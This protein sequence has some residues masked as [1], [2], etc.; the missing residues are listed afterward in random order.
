METSSS[1]ELLIAL[2]LLSGF[3]SAAETSLTTL[4]L[5]RVHDLVN[6]KRWSSHIIQRLKAHPEKL[7]IT[8]LIGNNIVNIWASVLAGQVATEYFGSHVVGYVVAVMTLVMLVFAEVLPKTL[9]QRFNTTF[10]QITSPLL[11]LLS[12]LFYPLIILLELLSRAFISLLGKEKFKTV[13]EDEVIAMLNIGHQEGEFN[14]QENEFIKNIFEFSD[15]TA[16]EIMTNRNEIEA[17]SY[18]ITLEEATR[19]IAKSSHTRIPIY[20]KEID[21]IIGYM[22]LKDII[23]LSKRKGNLQKKL[24]EFRLNKILFFPLSKPINV[25]FKN[26]QKE[27]IHIA[28]ILD[29]FGSTIGLVTM[30]DV[31]EEIVGDIEDEHDQEEKG[32]KRLNRSSYQVRGDTTMEELFTHH[33]FEAGVPEHKTVAFLIIKK[34]KAFPREGEKII[35]QDQGVEFV[36]E[37]MAEKTIQQVRMQVRN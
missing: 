21:N 3:F 36:V 26:F 18:D 33:R 8:I 7:L 14:K 24:L 1:I 6:K 37:K 12:Y 30:E 32:V 23:K 25:I 22:T 4:S 9:A 27:H 20:E 2:I 5:G 11:F 29:E 19:L 35:L 34:L 15:T 31:L 16:E 17:F 13:T 28:V 10:A